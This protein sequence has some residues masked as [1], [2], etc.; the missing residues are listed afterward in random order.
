MP[1]HTLLRRA[2]GACGALYR[3]CRGVSGS[4]ALA[5]LL[6]S[7]GAFAGKEFIGQMETTQEGSAQITQEG[8]CQGMEAA[9]LSAGSCGEG[10]TSTGTVASGTTDS[11]GSDKADRSQPQEKGCKPLEDCTYCTRVS[12]NRSGTCCKC[13]EDGDGSGETDCSG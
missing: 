4:T 10:A 3:N 13:D 2:V 1:F 11:S 8:V 5:L 9:G 6:L 7:A 12:C